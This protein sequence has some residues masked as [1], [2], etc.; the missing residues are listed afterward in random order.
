MI[1]AACETWL[2]RSIR[3]SAAA[4][5]CAAGLRGK[6]FAIMVEGLDGRIELVGSDEKIAVGR[7]GSET[8][9]VLLRGTPLDL[10]RLVGSDGD[11]LGRLRETRAELTGDVRVAE[12]FAKLFHLAR[13][14]LEEELAG[15]VGDLAAH[16]LGRAGRGFARFA[17]RAAL[18]VQQDLG[19]YLQQERALV[20]PALA[21]QAFYAEVER[22]RDAVERL[23]QRIGKLARRR[24]ARA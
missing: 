4:S 8:P 19:E 20:A 13:P 3:E 2:N 6:R 24:A 7:G 1:L 23:E 5:E 21:V 9:D 22:V 10:L 15:W 18:A 14:D 16:Q 12:S 11:A 17:G